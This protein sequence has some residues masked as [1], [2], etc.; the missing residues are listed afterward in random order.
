MELENNTDDT[1]HIDTPLTIE[2][3]IAALEE[4]GFSQITSTNGGK[5]NYGLFVARKVELS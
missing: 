2:N 1:K 3:E 4:A 5:E